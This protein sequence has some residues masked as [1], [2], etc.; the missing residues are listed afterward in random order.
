[1]DLVSGLVGKKY[2]TEF[3]VYKWWN[4]VPTISNV[5]LDSIS[6]VLADKSTS[7]SSLLLVIMARRATR[8][9]YAAPPTALTL[10]SSLA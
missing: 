2:P 10:T 7:I 8:F 9:R 5:K 3:G 1:M 6:L 4:V